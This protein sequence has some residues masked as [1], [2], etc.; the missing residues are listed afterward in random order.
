MT[1]MRKLFFGIILVATISDLATKAVAF[2]KLGHPER[3]QPPPRKVEVIR[4][5]VRFETALNK[6]VAF[7]M[8]N[9][10]GAR[11]ALAGVSA[12]AFPLIVFFFLRQKAPTWA[13]TAGLAGIAGGTLGNLYDRA[14]IGQ[15][16][17]F[18]YFYCINFPVFN[19]ADSFI[20]VGAAVFA[21]EHFL[22]PQK[23]D[24]KSDADAA[25]KAE[26]PA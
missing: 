13:F 19:V 18:I 12:I 5:V 3:V 22:S 2:R 15:V 7:G 23:E 8:L 17:D 16:R 1:A 21:L 11:W 6:G 14:V 20:C 26:T 9:D 24:A 4:G 25:A 10:A